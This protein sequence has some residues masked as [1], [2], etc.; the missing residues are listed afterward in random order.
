MALILND[1]IRPYKPIVY[2]TAFRLIPSRDANGVSWRYGYEVQR[3]P[4]SG[5]S[6]G[7]PVD[8][9][10]TDRPLSS[11]GGAFVDQLPPAATYY[12]YKW[13]QVGPGFSAGAY[14]AYIKRAADVLPQ[15]VLDVAVNSENIYP[16][17]RAQPFTDAK[18]ALQATNDT[19][20]VAKDVTIQD[21]AAKLVT[22]FANAV[23]T[24]TDG[25]G[26]PKVRTKFGK[27]GAGAA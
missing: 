14:S 24:V 25:Q 10:V 23:V 4:D 2:G 22:D 8:I 20:T 3:A 7:T 17:E 16:L 6:P 19:G 15:S 27:V 13:R 21:T 5:G 9:F 1:I 18:F 12:H 26:S 11:S